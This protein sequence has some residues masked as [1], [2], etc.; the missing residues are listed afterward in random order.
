MDGVR[1][2]S[3]RGCGAECSTA[4]GRWEGTWI[5]GKFCLTVGRGSW[6][7]GRGFPL[8][9]L[10]IYARMPTVIVHM[11]ADTLNIRIDNLTA[12]HDFKRLVVGL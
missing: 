3:D 10:R 4:F 7:S 11:C 1:S 8:R 5:G 2:N 12:A 9:G 6:I